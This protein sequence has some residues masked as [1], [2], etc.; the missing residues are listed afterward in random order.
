[1]QHAGHAN[2][3]HEGEPPG[4]LGGDVEAGHRPPHDRVGRRIF[5]R[6]LRVDLQRKRT[7][8]EQLAVRRLLAARPRSDGPVLHHQIAGG[9][10]E[11]LR[12]L[13]H[14][15]APR[16]GGRLADLHPALLDGQAAGRDALIR[17]ERG[18]ALDDGD[19]LQRHVQ[20]V[21]RNL[22]DGRAHARPEVDLA[23]K[24]GDAAPRIDREEGVDLVGRERPRRGAAPR[25]AR[26]QRRE[27]EAHDEDA[28]AP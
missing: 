4:D 19:E 10:A 18:V 22:G 1:M 15:R 17:G 24:D 13:L 26:H 8:A 16:G 2:V 6:R 27:R 3:L 28:G 23:G 12:R 25:A 9:Y 5:E 20:L 21:G 11:P 7:A 14:Q